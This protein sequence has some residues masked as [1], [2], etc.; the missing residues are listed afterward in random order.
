[1]SGLFRE[2][3]PKLTRFYE[4]FLLA[5][6]Q[7]ARGGTRPQAMGSIDLSRRGPHLPTPWYSTPRRR[8]LRCC[9]SASRRTAS[10]S[11]L[12]CANYRDQPSND[13]RNR[14][15]AAHVRW[16]GRRTCPRCVG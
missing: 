14:S 15:G 2:D 4:D 3:I 8:R 12:A 9:V 11:P 7:T 16:H 1:M 5:M 13:L 6:A 10:A